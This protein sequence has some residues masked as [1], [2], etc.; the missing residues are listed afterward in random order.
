MNAQDYYERSSQRDDSF[1]SRYLI[2]SGV[3]NPALVRDS[4]RRLHDPQSPAPTIPDQHL[5][6]AETV[7]QNT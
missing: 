3:F 7:E 1:D 5:L 6:N 4:R 2:T